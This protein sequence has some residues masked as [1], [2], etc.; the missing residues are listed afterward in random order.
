MV[1]PIGDARLACRVALRLKDEVAT[2]VA[3]KYADGAPEIELARPFGIPVR[4]RGWGFLLLCSTLYVA[5]LYSLRTLF[6][7]WD[8]ADY[9]ATSAVVIG[10]FVFSVLLHEAAHAFV[11]VRNGVP[12]AEVALLTIGARVS[13]RRPLPASQLRLTALFA[14]AGP[15]ADLSVALVLALCAALSYERAPHAFGACLVALVINL[16][17]AASNLLPIAPLDGGRIFR[18]GV[19]AAKARLGW[20]SDRLGLDS[21]LRLDSTSGPTEAA[22]QKAA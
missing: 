7:T 14:A 13:L 18:C 22:E 9:F 8:L 12:V 16:S 5:C 17:L 3:W 6:P 20:R 11:A 10:L 1:R 15:L 19:L 2:I 4:L 21:S